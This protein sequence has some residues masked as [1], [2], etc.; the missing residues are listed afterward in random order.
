MGYH[1]CR[2]LGADSEEY[3]PVL[4]HHTSPLSGKA[5]RDDDGSVHFVH[6]VLAIPIKGSPSGNSVKAPA[7]EG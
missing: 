2:C 1:R 4:E 3:I 7:E 5:V 6:S